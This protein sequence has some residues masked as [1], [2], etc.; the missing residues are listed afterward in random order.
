MVEVKTVVSVLMMF[1]D[2]HTLVGICNIV[3]YQA[4]S[5]GHGGTCTCT[6]ITVKFYTWVIDEQ[7]CRDIRLK[8]TKRGIRRERDGEKE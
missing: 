6:Y 5:N 7:R 1:P 8:E 2:S 3:P 4:L